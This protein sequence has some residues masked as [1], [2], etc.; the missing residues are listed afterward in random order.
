MLKIIGL[1]S[2]ILLLNL[3]AIEESKETFGYGRIQTSFQDDK[4][5][6]CFMAPGAGSKYRLGNECESWIEL[7][8]SQNIKLD[9]DINIHNQV[10]PSFM[11]PNNEKIDFFDWAEV[12]SEISNIFNN[13]ISFWIGRRLYKRVESHINDYWPL[14]TSGTGLGVDGISIFDNTKLNYALFFDRLNPTTDTSDK[15]IYL[16]RNDI[17]F[18]IDI[19]NSKLTLFLNY[20]HVNSQGF[21]SQHHL[22]SENGYASAIVLK[23][24]TIFQKLFDLKGENVTGLFYGAG[25]GKD[26]GEYLPYPDKQLKNSELIENLISNPNA[27]DKSNTWRVFN[28]NSIESENF[29]IIS[30]FVYE[31]LKDKA[32]A[33]KKQKWLSAGIRPYWFVG[34]NFRLTG[35]LGYDNIDNEIEN[36]NYNLIKTTIATE[37]AL[38]K[39][40]WSRPVVRL[41][42]TY[43]SW[44]DSAKGEIGG[45]YYKNDTNGDNIGIQLE[46][47][48]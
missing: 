12:Y 33:N 1:I 48:W 22:N 42:Y 28:Y 38:D 7:G 20:L 24:D 40:V 16:Y 8:I 30:A 39:G 14:N 10:R 15:D 32:F 13:D 5:N 45:D 25:I 19:S 6:L 35:E 4:E 17:R 46:Y 37:F 11:G 23:N 3:S 21:D 27:I 41:F 34:K 31:D 44:S 18:D 47:W 29:G 2:I 43:A 36:K 9:N 26:A